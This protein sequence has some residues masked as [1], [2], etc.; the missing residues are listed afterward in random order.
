MASESQ[1]FN[2]FKQHYQIILW[3]I[4]VVFLISEAT[5]F[6]AYQ[7]HVVSSDII[8]QAGRQRMY[9]QK[10]AK[11]TLYYQNGDQF[12]IQDL[13]ET[14]TRWSITHLSFMDE[15]SPL[16][17]FYF[18]N[19]SIQRNFVELTISQNAIET[20]VN[21]IVANPQI[22]H[23]ENI[24]IVMENEGRFLVLMDEIVNQMETESGQQYYKA[25]ITEIFIG[26]STFV[27]LSMTIFF[28]LVPTINNLRA[29]ETELSVS[30]NEKKALLAEIHHRVKNNLAII[31]G[32]FQLQIMNKNYSRN[33]FEN[34]VTRV[35]SIASIHEFL[36]NEEEV[37]SVKI[38]E[39]VNELI[40]RLSQSYPELGKQIKVNVIADSILF[41]I[42]KAVPFSLLLNELITNSIKHGFRPGDLGAIDII[43]TL[44][45]H[46]IVHF[47]YMDNGRGMAYSPK[48]ESGI[49]MQLIKALS[50]QLDTEIEVSY[51]PSFILSAKFSLI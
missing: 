24:A 41:D 17:K 13:Q 44:T 43:L 21:E 40:K 47:K 50:D 31:S 14:V 25:T 27:A 19:P 5:K 22:D 46:G 18:S 38:D 15:N 20:A 33:T 23:T 9:S 1:I 45:E 8:N 10:I 16:S 32:M 4:I 7:D 29:K 49:G 11:L 42:E 6:D 2:Y 35:Q 12:A 26:I 36:Y 37:S 30:I 51:S 34:A 39:Y 48:G 3:V 28:L